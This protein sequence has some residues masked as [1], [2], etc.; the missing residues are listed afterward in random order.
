MGVSVASPSDINHRCV[1]SSQ[2]KIHIIQKRKNNSFY[3]WGEL[4]HYHL[5]LLA[6]SGLDGSFISEPIKL[7]FSIMLKT[8]FF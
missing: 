8:D 7:R 1:Y 3:F 2:E 5:S 6:N 4:F